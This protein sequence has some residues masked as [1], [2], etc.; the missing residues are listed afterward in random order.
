M[1][2]VTM[3]P[4]MYCIWGKVQGDKYKDIIQVEILGETAFFTSLMHYSYFPKVHDVN[5]VTRF[6]PRL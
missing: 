1:N 2:Q 6:E 4:Y 3:G 5:H